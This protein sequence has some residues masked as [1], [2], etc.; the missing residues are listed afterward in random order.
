[1]I[2]I[3]VEVDHVTYFDQF[4]ATK[5]IGRSLQKCIVV[6][7]MVIF[8]YYHCQ[9]NAAT[10]LES[11]TN[12]LS[13]EASNSGDID[14]VQQVGSGLLNGMSNVLDVSTKSELSDTKH[15]ERHDSEQ[16]PRKFNAKSNKVRNYRL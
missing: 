6:N 15:D 10:M 8:H 14:V 16:Q 1:M 7:G 5:N 11:M 13:K 2:I 3:R 4:G 12:Y 9:G